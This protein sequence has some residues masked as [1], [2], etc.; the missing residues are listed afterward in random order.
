MFGSKSK[1]KDLEKR[2]ETQRTHLDHF[3]DRANEMESE[4]QRLKEE[5]EA[6]KAHCID[7]Y[8]VI[9]ITEG[10]C[11]IMN[12]II[13][14]TIKNENGEDTCTIKFDSIKTFATYVKA[15]NDMNIEY[16]GSHLK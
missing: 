13:D 7:Q 1:V 12:L 8:H 2:L 16:L 5:N 6:L 10:N 15:M 11:K 3:R 14:N 9:K 4:N